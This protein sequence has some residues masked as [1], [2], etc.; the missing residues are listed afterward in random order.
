MSV[1]SG[2]DLK[3]DTKNEFG[4]MRLEFDVELVSGERVDAS[5]SV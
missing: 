3:G 2:Q 4:G 5:A 1:P